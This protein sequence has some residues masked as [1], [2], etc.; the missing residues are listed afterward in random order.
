MNK[1][2]KAP[3]PIRSIPCLF[4][5]NNPD[6]TD[7]LILNLV[8]VYFHGNGEDIFHALELTSFL[9]QYLNLNVLSV[10]YPGYSTYPMP[11]NN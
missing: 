10:E 9:K 6:S 11:S 8:L 4:Q 1:E 3:L 5:E 2:G 7:S